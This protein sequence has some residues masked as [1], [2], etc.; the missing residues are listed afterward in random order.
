VLQ[1]AGR[2]LAEENGI[3]DAR[4]GSLVCYGEQVLHIDGRPQHLRESFMP[5]RCTPA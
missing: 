4:F 5:S 2:E 3:V 1:A